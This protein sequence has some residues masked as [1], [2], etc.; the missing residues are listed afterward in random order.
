M[1]C[2]ILIWWYDIL[3]KLTSQQLLAHFSGSELFWGGE[4]W[5]LTA[6][7]PTGSH[8]TSSWAKLEQ[9][10]L[11][12]RLVFE[13]CSHLFQWLKFWN[14]LN[15][16]NHGMMVMMITICSL[17]LWC[18][19]VNG[20]Q[21]PAELQGCQGPLIRK[22]AAAWWSSSGNSKCGQIYGRYG[23]SAA[24]HS[25]DHP[26]HPDTEV[27]NR[28]GSAFLKSCVRGL[29]LLHRRSWQNYRAHN[30]TTVLTITVAPGLRIIGSKVFCQP[31]R[32]AALERTHKSD[33]LR[34]LDPSFPFSCPS[35]IL[36]KLMVMMAISMRTWWKHWQ[37][38]WGRTLHTSQW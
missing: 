10:S 17:L 2:T 20:F 23:T 26:Q 1:Q 13:H 9:V 8:A 11:F 36:Q 19:V 7:S 12:A 24:L 29:A 31:G 21:Y 28:C 38:I 5:P 32:I 14:V 3:C 6:G 22:P 34:C 16:R 4:T 37:N 35:T 15:A 18:L 30:H 25:I 33:W 27:S